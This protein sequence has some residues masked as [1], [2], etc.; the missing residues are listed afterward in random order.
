MRL[1]FEPLDHAVGPG[2]QLEILGVLRKELE[3]L[4]GSEIGPQSNFIAPSIDEGVEFPLNGLRFTVDPLIQRSRNI[5]VKRIGVKPLIAEDEVGGLP[6]LIAACLDQQVC[7]IC[8]LF[9]DFLGLATTEHGQS[10]H[11]CGCRQSSGRP[12]DAKVTH[13]VCSV[14]EW[15]CNLLVIVW[16]GLC[17]LGESSG[18]N[19]NR[20]G[21]DSGFVYIGRG[22]RDEISDLNQLFQEP[23]NAVQRNHV[24]AITW[25]LVGIRM[26]FKKQSV[27]TNGYGGSC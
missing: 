20:V 14:L 16:Q 19:Q 24:R 10:D 6:E 25:R 13:G 23:F 9:L 2:G 11:E 27:D 4:H 8:R 7:R 22:F 15:S 12:P 26:C 18:A 17:P 21:K 3:F 1:L 5:V